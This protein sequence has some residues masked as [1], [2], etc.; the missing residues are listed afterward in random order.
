MKR[1]VKLGSAGVLTIAIFMSFAMS[2]SIAG[3]ADQ[4]AGQSEPKYSAAPGTA[5]SQTIDDATL[6]Q[7]ARVFVKVKQ[8]AQREKTVADDAKDEAEKQQIMQQAQS[9]K[10][11]AV[12][13]EGLQPQRYDQ[14]LQIV[15]ADTSLQQKFFSYVNQPGDFGNKTM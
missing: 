13:A 9:E 7:A 4:T 14:I 6:K 1:L 12:K 10:L 15:Q 2:P 3:T 8:I 5:G 11:A